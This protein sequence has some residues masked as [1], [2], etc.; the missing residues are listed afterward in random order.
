MLLLPPAWGGRPGKPRRGKKG[1]AERQGKA[2]GGLV[3]VPV[4][5]GGP[6]PR[7]AVRAAPP[8]PVPLL[9]SRPV[10]SRR[11]WGHRG[12]TGGCCCLGGG[13]GW[14]SHACPGVIALRRGTGGRWAPGRSCRFLSYTH[15][16]G[17]FLAP[18]CSP[19]CPSMDAR[20]GYYK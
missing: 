13:C 1:K 7:G 9:P 14:V 10:P 11:P 18:S 8:A 3:C 5:R 20:R 17:V 15:F 12:P 4:R 2:G 16:H 6:V 19:L